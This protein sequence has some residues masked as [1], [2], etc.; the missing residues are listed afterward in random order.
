MKFNPSRSEREQINLILDKH[1]TT[2]MSK[3]FINTLKLLIEKNSTKDSEAVYD[4]TIAEK[5]EE[6]DN[7]I[8]ELANLRKS[9]PENL[10]E[11]ILKE[12]EK[13]TEKI[14]ELD[15]EN[16][17]TKILDFEENNF[18]FEDVKYE[19]NEVVKAIPEVVQK[20][21]RAKGYVDDKNV[22]KDFEEVVLKYFENIE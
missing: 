8:V 22:E 21:E 12:T 2:P 1:A 18:S 20:A 7:L 14:L 10:K 13:I 11:K 9:L 3:K 19:V 17:K 6:R 4:Y 5:E 16:D 15:K